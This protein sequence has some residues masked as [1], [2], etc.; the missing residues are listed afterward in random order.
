VSD[1]DFP[2]LLSPQETAD[3]LHTKTST[4]AIWRCT[5][6]YPE[7]PWVKIGRKVLYKEEDVRSFIEGGVTR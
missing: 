7:L 6:R 1:T 5:K 3:R 2:R 4:L